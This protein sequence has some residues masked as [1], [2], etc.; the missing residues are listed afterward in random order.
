MAN[1][2]SR[3]DIARDEFVKKIALAIFRLAGKNKDN[4]SFVNK[5]SI[6]ILVEYV[7]ND[8][9]FLDTGDFEIQEIAAGI[10][11]FEVK[12]NTINNTTANRNLLKLIYEDD[13]YIINYSNII[14]MLQEFYPAI[15]I[16]DVS[17]SG[18]TI[19]MS[20]KESFLAKYINANIKSF[21]NVMLHNCK[22][23]IN[24]S[25][26]CAK[27]IINNT[28]I[29]EANRATYIGYLNTK[30]SELLDIDD[31]NLWNE[32]LKNINALEYSAINIVSYFNNQCN[33]Q[34]NEV[35]INFINGKGTVISF[36][37]VFDNNNDNERMSFISAIVKAELLN[38]QIYEGYIEQFSLMYM[39]FNI[40]DLPIEKL[41]ILDKHKK[42]GMT[43]KSLQF[44]REHYKE[45]L[46]TFITNHIDEYINVVSDESVIMF[47]EIHNLLDHQISDE[48]KIE[49]LKLPSAAQWKISIQGKKYSDELTA[50]I[51]QNN[52]DV[53]DFEHL[54]KEYET[55]NNRI[56]EII[57]KLSIQNI[58][59][60]QHTMLNNASHLLIHDVL[61]SDRVELK[62]RQSV[63]KDI[64]Y[65]ANDD[66]IKQWLN[67][68]ELNDFLKLYEERTRPTFENTI[69]NKALL[70]IFKNRNLIADYELDA[71]NNKYK[72]SR[73]K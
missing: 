51:L 39:H 58:S 47:E 25:Q 42:I 54:I 72:I 63:F 30:I 5:D 36:S 37:E 68:V 15:N 45:Y 66:D 59:S 71:N 44:I 70:D 38:N 65:K 50:H 52:Y 56:R 13:S 2:P 3:L 12:F 29:D 21:M 8:S 23:K 60:L 61:S 27:L 57:L 64:A 33:N 11:L 31:T 55:F 6:D 18:Y 32:M 35:L 22:G 43:D 9:D 16:D 26:E 4:M 19:I 10:K 17:T 28:E 53:A 34:F 46:F 67:L 24:D 14:T 48:R 20:D 41:T 40:E 7:S 1:K 69:F 73:R 62:I 49:L